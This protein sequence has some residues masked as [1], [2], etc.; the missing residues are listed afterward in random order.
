MDDTLNG[1]QT[2]GAATLKSFYK[3]SKTGQKW[4]RNLM[5]ISVSEVIEK[6]SKTDQGARVIMKSAI[7]VIRVVKIPSLR[8][9]W[10]SSMQAWICIPDVSSLLPRKI[11]HAGQAYY[12]YIPR[13]CCQYPPMQKDPQHAS[14]I[15]STWIQNKWYRCEDSVVSG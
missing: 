10:K 6:Q 15:C 5:I 11:G 8:R 14:P 1:L 9:S 13:L 2:I 7:P 3:K 12:G 4:V